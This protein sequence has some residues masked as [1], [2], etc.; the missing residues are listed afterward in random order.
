MFI[1]VNTT[2]A[3]TDNN[4][5]GYFSP[6]ASWTSAGDANL[7]LAQPDPRDGDL[8]VATLAIRPAS[9]TIN[10]PLRLDTR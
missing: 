2:S 1:K 8:M 7:A 5:I 10:T 6:P 3:T 4:N 9:S